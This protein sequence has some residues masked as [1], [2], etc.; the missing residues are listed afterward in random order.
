V[1]GL[2]WSLVNL[3]DGVPH[4]V[5]VDDLQWADEASQRFLA[6]V[7]ARL[8]GLA[9][10]LIAAARTG[11]GPMPPPLVAI[12]HQPEATTLRPRALSARAVAAVVHQVLG[13]EADAAFVDACVMATGGVPFYVRELLV[14]LARDRVEPTAA[15]APRIA[16]VRAGSVARS[17][18]ARVAHLP[19][20]AVT[21]AQGLAVLGDTG[22]ESLL[23]E[24]AGTSPDATRQAV[25]GMRTA[26]LLAPDHLAFAH[27]I[28]GA[29]IYDDVP[30]ATRAEMHAR[31]ALL[32]HDGGGDNERVAAHLLRTPPG[33]GSWAVDVLRAAANLALVR[34]GAAEATVLLRRARAEP[35]DTN[36]RARLLF[37]LGTAEWQ[38]G[39]PESIEHLQAAM[40]G[41]RETAWW[42]EAVV[43]LGR[44]LM[45][46]GRLGDAA[47][48]LDTASS[49]LTDASPELSLRLQLEF[50][51]S[52]RPTH[53]W[54]NRAVEYIV[55]LEPRLAGLD[56]PAARLLL[57]DRAMH[58]AQANE[59]ASAVVERARRA[60]GAGDLPAR[61]PPGSLHYW[62]LVHALICGG[63]LDTAESVLQAL[64]AE[65]RRQGSASG[66]A[67]GRLLRAILGLRRGS[68]LEA[69]ADALEGLGLARDHFP[70][71]LPLAVGVAVEG[72]VEQ[73]DTARA[74]QVLAANT[75]PPALVGPG[76]HDYY[77][78]GRG[79]LRLAQRRWTEARGDLLQAGTSMLE[80]NSPGPAVLAWRSRAAV[81]LAAL[82]EQAEAASLAADEVALAESF[83][84]PHTLGVALRAAG[85]VTPGPEGLEQ[86]ERSVA[87]LDET[88]FELEAAR[89]LT[90]LGT[91]LRRQGRRG[92]ARERLRRGL[93]LAIR[94][95]A[96][97]IAER[98]RRELIAS[99]ARP[100]RTAITGVA[101]LTATERRTCLLAA[102]GLTNRD[103]AQELFVTVKTVEVHLTASYR[104]L[105]I[106]SR[107]QLAARLDQ[108]A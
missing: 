87:V 63:D 15:N 74:E 12:E 56:T 38:A 1:H 67:M 23:A 82:G 46:H 100:R 10:G 75:I 81:A 60:W 76:F 105:G 65:A 71:G 107:T 54:Q 86:L 41:A 47:H 95:G 11:V 104:K 27:P 79:L 9:L 57:A 52:A 68:L 16:D 4:L 21:V 53:A 6:F 49:Q 30:S 103:I 106:S 77:L 44:A 18:V 91:L 90:D 84:S 92:D 28:V 5:V 43:A 72:L 59:A 2:Y 61:E 24:L 85:L 58:G 101:A 96:L 14:E 94:C 8:G 64:L 50:V 78:A 66:Y 97:P 7:A 102:Q 55:E 31:A 99:G 88:P 34:G 89:A 3:C 25:A 45:A 83:G 19:A 20:D 36:V 73:G 42:G 51:V 39:R 62:P 37:E 70:L 108:Q 17:V 48:L 32:V 98:A 35:H 29:S 80:W 69:E 40:D 22:T 13:I 33:T 93:D 26:G